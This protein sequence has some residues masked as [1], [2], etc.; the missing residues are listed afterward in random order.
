MKTHAGRGCQNAEH[1]RPSQPKVLV[2]ML[3]RNDLMDPTPD[4]LLLSM[5]TNSEIR[6]AVQNSN[7]HKLLLYVAASSPDRGGRRSPGSLG[8]VLHNVSN[9]C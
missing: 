5:L 2:S 4:S 7:Q 8:M 1:S 9:V 3:I 6:T